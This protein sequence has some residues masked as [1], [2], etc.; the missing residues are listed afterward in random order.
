M[1][2]TLLF[3][4]IKISQTILFLSK[5]TGQVW[6]NLYFLWYEEL[7]VTPQTEKS[8]SIC[9]GRWKMKVINIEI[10]KKG[11]IV[12]DGLIIKKEKNISKISTY[13]FTCIRN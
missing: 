11:V 2:R 6:Y 13:S 8:D 10:N 3:Y 12:F 4:S 1:M 5:V 9:D 7:F